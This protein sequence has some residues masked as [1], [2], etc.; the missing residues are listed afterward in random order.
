MM[1]RF[2]LICAF[3]G[4]ACAAGRARQLC[5]V[6]YGRLRFLRS[7]PLPRACHGTVGTICLPL[8]RSTVTDSVPRDNAVTKKSK[9]SRFLM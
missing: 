4:S 1:L 5:H 7:I 9:A 8:A 2:Y 3:L 6:C